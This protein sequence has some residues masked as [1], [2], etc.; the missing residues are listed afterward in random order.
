[1]E[2]VTG[3]NLT[4]TLYDMNGKIIRKWSKVQKITSGEGTRSYVYF[5]TADDKY[6]QIPDSVWYVAEEE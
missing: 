4:I 5:Y 6:V 3:Q 1:V 2:T